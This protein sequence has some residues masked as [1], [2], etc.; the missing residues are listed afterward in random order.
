MITDLFGL[1]LTD[2]VQAVGY[3]GIFFIVF[4]ESGLPFGFFFP[5]DSLLF[6]AGLLASQGVFSL[7]PLLLLTTSAAIL[8]D[9]AGY[10]LGHRY[11]KKLFE[12][13]GRWF[14][15]DRTLQKTESFY[16]RYGARAL[17]FARFVPTVR[18]FVPIFAGIGSMRYRTFL[19][20]NVVGGVLWGTGVTSLGY[21]L[22]NTVPHIEEYLH[23]IILGI[24]VVSFLPL[25]YEYVQARRK[26]KSDKV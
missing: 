13:K 12:R 7:V 23:Y 24:I 21:A 9:S 3:A 22:G 6:V 10:A 11:G 19:T 14:F 16:A 2:L 26:K 5:G 25:V 17:I 1:P 18:T 8:G 20:Y 4:S 15:N